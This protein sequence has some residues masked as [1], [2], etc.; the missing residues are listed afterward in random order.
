MKKYLFIAMAVVCSMLLT[1]C[2]GTDDGGEQQQEETVTNPIKGKS[3]INVS[4]YEYEDEYGEMQEETE[5]NILNFTTLE[6]GFLFSKYESATDSD[7]ETLPFK[8]SFHMNSGTISLEY[9]VDDVEVYPFTYNEQN[10]TI[11]LRSSYG[12]FSLVFSYHKDI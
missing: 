2:P 5:T 1:A 8:Y 9:D 12:D 3:Y 11:T 4:T 7:E 10:N 6:D